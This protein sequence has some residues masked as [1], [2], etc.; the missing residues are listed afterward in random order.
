MLLRNVSHEMNLHISPS[1]LLA[2]LVKILSGM[3]K[4]DSKKMTVF[5]HI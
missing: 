5:V 3:F 1:E 2:T 4:V